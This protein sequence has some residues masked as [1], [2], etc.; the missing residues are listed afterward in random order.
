MHYRI[1]GKT[2]LKVSEIGFG[3]W[4]MGG[5]WNI[6]GSGIGYAGVNDNDSVQALLK[7]L[8]MGVNLIDTADAY[9]AGHSENV[10]GKTMQ[11]RWDNV[12]LATKVGNE[13]RD[14][15][16]GRKNLDP[17]YIQQ[18]CENSLTRL[19]KETIDIY[20][21]HGPT[22]EH[23]ATDKVF[24]T[25]EKLKTSGKIRFYG[26][27]V[28][29]VEQAEKY[30]VAGQVD[31]IQLHY[32]IL[33]RQSE[34]KILNLAQ[35]HNVGII[36]RVPLSS[37]LLSGKFTSSTTFDN[38]DHRSNWLKE[39]KLKTAIAQ[40]EQLK[41]IAEQLQITLPELALRYVL[42]T[43]LVHTTIPGAKNVAQAEANCLASKN[44]KLPQDVI[45]QIQDLIPGDF[46]NP[47]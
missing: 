43:P 7:A 32:S 26:V 9:G 47:T 5:G 37:G 29:K 36:A 11:H 2:K 34:T 41:P 28:N 30:I 22:A 6:A 13:R 21:L 17:A 46:G 42:Q 24:E 23:P 39:E 1:L 45:E 44:E 16:P 10:I 19:R 31:V 40:V 3:A 20:Q 27:S 12:Y 8:D 38:T 33:D 14:P 18:A 15:L 35:E 25:L 4:A